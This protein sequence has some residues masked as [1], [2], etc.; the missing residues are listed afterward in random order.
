MS[1]GERGEFDGKVALVTGASRGI[2]L[3]IAA[4]FVAQG[5][6]VAITARK[7]DELNAAVSTLGKDRAIGVQGAADDPDHRAEATRRAV[8]ELGRL[9]VLVNGAAV[10][11]YYG[12]LIEADLRAVRKIF[13]VNVVSLLAWCQEAWQVW[14]AENGGT[15]INI[16]SVGG[17]VPGEGLGAYNASKAAVIHLTRQL[18]GEL[19]PRVRVNAVAPAVV[20]TR[21]AAKLWQGN[22]ERAKGDYPMGRFGE[23]SDVAGAVAF[24]VSE[25]AGWISGETLVLDGGLASRPRL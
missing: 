7:E 5:A 8:K 16:A 3:A 13:D 18:A 9:D 10:N 14:M 2:G 1:G 24:L 11:P 23:P 22:E 4:E 20:K 25:R 12:P 21:F 17:L 15:I 19:G 6:S